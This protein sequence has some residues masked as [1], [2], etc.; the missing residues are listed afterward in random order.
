MNIFQFNV[1]LFLFEIHRYSKEVRN[2]KI[3]ELKF[4]KINCQ[5]DN[6]ENFWRRTRNCLKKSKKM[7]SGFKV[8]DLSFSID[9]KFFEKVTFPNIHFYHFHGSFLWFLTP[10]LSKLFLKKNFLLNWFCFENLYRKWRFPTTILT[11]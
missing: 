8:G 4:R 7:M 10:A 9:H 1:N 11:N 3:L 5:R 2:F 6:E